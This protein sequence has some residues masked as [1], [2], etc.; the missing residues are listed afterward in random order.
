MSGRT[1]DR[2]VIVVGGADGHLGSV[3]A[4]ELATLG[5]SVVRCTHR[6]AAAGAGVARA[7]DRYG[8][9]DAVVAADLDDSARCIERYLEGTMVLVDAALA[10]MDPAS[11]GR[12]VGAGSG[13]G[14]F[15]N[16][17]NPQHAAAAAGVIA[18]IRS[19]A[20]ALRDT[21]IRANVVSAVL[22]SSPVPGRCE[23]R[24]IAPAVAYLCHPDCRVNGEIWSAGRGRFAAIFTG[25]APGYFEP[26]PDIDDIAEHVDVI[27]ERDHV[28]YPRRA[29]D[30]NLLIDV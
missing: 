28:V 11:P 19:I 7:I 15:G 20:L 5:A 10:V 24:S 14:V 29:E 6:G 3:V 23:A 1:L 17:W 27:Q 22:G 8:R 12:I 16:S 4:H 26:E 2:R 30:E 18:Y 9:I 13:A 21:Q 25:T